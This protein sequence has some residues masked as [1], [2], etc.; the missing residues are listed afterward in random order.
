MFS[1]Y[2]YK[3]KLQHIFE[4]N[5][6]IVN[7]LNHQFS[8]TLSITLIKIKRNKL[9]FSFLINSFSFY[10]LVQVIEIITKSINN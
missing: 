1:F 9:L 3:N 7:I 6:V 8:N 2:Y 5:K 4:L 10:F